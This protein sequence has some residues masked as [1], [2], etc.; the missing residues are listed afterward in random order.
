MTA[1][2]RIA[3][4]NLNQITDRLILMTSKSCFWHTDRVREVEY[5][6]RALQP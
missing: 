1:T 3:T 5:L 4:A 6:S 2:N